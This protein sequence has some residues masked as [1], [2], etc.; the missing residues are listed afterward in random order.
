MIYDKQSPCVSLD[1]C[2]L[3]CEEVCFSCYTAC[4]L[5]ALLLVI[6]DVYNEMVKFTARCVHLGSY[7]DRSDISL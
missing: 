3:A 6:D 2:H 5:R 4:S 7:S 1:Q